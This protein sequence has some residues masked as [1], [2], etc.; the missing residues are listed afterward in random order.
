MIELE[1][2]QFK[3]DV[4]DIGLLKVSRSFEVSIMKNWATRTGYKTDSL[5]PWSE[6]KEDIVRVYDYLQTLDKAIVLIPLRKW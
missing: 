6:V 4:T 2:K 1:D 3:V 5:F